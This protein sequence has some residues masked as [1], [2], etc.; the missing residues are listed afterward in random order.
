[1]PVTFV[2]NTFGGKVSLVLVHP[3]E[4]IQWVGEG[5]EGAEGLQT[6]HGVCNTG[7][8]CKTVTN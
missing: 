7:Q 8:N 2:K 4:N 1:M 6:A 5:R 3:C